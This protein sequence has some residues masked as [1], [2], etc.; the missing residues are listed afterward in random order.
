MRKSLSTRDLVTSR[1]PD[2]IPAYNREMIRLFSTS[3]R[4]AQHVVA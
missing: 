3:H 1:R 4:K 2:D